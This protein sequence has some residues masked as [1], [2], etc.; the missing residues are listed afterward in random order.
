MPITTLNKFL[1][2][3]GSIFAATT[4]QELQEVWSNQEW[5]MEHPNDLKLIQREL[6]G[7]YNDKKQKLENI[8]KYEV[9]IP[10]W[11]AN[12]KEIPSTFIGEVVRETQK[13]YL[14]RGTG[15]IVQTGHCMI[16]NRELTNPVSLKYGIGIQCGQHWGVDP[17]GESH[18]EILRGLKEIAN[19]ETWI[20]KSQ[21][22][23]KEVK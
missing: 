6:E 2:I 13:A 10:R 23:H 17:E 22:K 7:F 9:T 21:I 19:F 8:K 4:L 5:D 11:L 3:K 20:P 18:E 1:Q 12:E 15:D 14:M 16:C